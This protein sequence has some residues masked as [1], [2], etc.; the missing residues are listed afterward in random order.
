MDILSALVLLVSLVLLPVFGVI[1]IVLRI[2]KK[3]TKKIKISFFVALGLFVISVIAV[4]VLSCNHEWVNATCNEPKV[5]VLCG[6]TNGDAT[7]HQWVDATCTTAKACAVCGITEGNSNG[8]NWIDATCET[9]KTC[10][11]CKLI[12]GNP[13]GHNWS[14][15]SCST[16]KQCSVCE[17]TDG[18]PL[19]HDTPSMTCTEEAE[20]VRCKEIIKAPGHTVKDATCTEVSICT[21]CH[22][23]LSEALG[24][25]WADATCE[26]P[27]TCAICNI[28]NGDP[29]GHIWEDATCTEPKACSVCA[30]T[31]GKALGHSWIKAT[32]TEAQTCSV[33]GVLYGEPFGHK[34]VDATCVDAAKCSVC[35]VTDGEAL[36]HTT[37]CGDCTRCGQEVYATVAGYGD[38]VL[39]GISVGDGIYRVHFTHTGRHNFVVK[40]YDTTNDY[41]LLINEIGKYDGYVLLLGKGPFAFE[42]TA[43]G[44]WTYTI[45]PLAKIS[46]TGFSG[47]GDY[48]TGLCDISSGAW[49]FTHDGKHN[50][51]V[52]IYTTDGRDL[53]VNEIGQYSGKK[54][55]NIPSSSLAFFEINA[56]GNW[57]IEKS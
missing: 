19:G 43:D 56:D 38:D 14:D 18:E 24:H 5:C 6:E 47:T 33:C 20:C 31:D 53:L 37:S 21:V 16:A 12:D 54:M 27:Q 1:W 4:V 32:C 17:N 10:L 13:L 40:A 23:V 49:K 7:G 28:T 8:H 52:R 11:N 42:I 50:F 25:A 51:V 36:G 29:L 3:N 34:W 35:G 2:R 39:S 44:S 57:T 30:I 22:E 9:S 26:L 46:D 15:A 48:V 41:E 55:V 45:E